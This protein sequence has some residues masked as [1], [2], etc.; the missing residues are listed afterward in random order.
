MKLRMDYSHRAAVQEFQRM[1]RGE[2]IC[3]VIGGGSFAFYVRRDTD[4]HLGSEMHLVESEEEMETRIAYLM[5]QNSRFVR[6][7]ADHLVEPYEY[8]SKQ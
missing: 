6:K 4:L 7:D 8:R 2:G 5:G 1:F 3:K